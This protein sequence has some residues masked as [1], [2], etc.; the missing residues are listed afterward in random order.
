MDQRVLVKGVD[1]KLIITIKE[2]NWIDGNNSLRTYINNN[3]KFLEKA[4]IIIDLKDIVLNSIDL[5][6]LRNFLNDNQI[7]LTSIL[8][9]QDETNT[10]A[11][12]LGLTSQRT[13]KTKPNIRQERSSAL[14]HASTIKKTIRSGMIIE[15]CLDIIIVG[16]VN[17][18]AIIRSTGNII[19]WGKLLGEAHAGV[20]GDLSAFIGALEMKPSLLTIAEVQFEG[21]KRKC[22]EPEI[23][24]L[25]KG[26]IHIES[27]KK[28]FN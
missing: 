3:K 10:A 14:K 12:L 11:R 2:S 20:A 7:S 19:G 15:D 4:K 21:S 28:T 27:W 9:T 17:P 23:A 24:F 1:D 6:D 13:E 8:S 18:G 26:S 22:N 5:F 25:K 16:E